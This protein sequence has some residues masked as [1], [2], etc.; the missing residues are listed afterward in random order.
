MD[1]PADVWM[2]A[3]D[4][5]KN[6]KNTLEPKPHLTEPLFFLP[7]L[8]IHRSETKLTE[9]KS[10]LSSEVDAAASTISTIIADSM[11][12]E[13]VERMVSQ[14]KVGRTAA[15]TSVLLLVLLLIRKVLTYGVTL[16]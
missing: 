4:I 2:C 11:D 1:A 12:D 14:A 6:H 16:L 10:R 15:Y 13:A 3:H 9:L 8:Y 5:T 7:V